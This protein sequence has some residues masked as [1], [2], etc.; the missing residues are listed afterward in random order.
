MRE[1]LLERIKNGYYKCKFDDY[2]SSEKPKLLNIDPTEEEVKKYLSELEKYNIYIDSYSNI[3]REREKKFETFKKDLFD[4][5]AYDI[6]STNKL[7]YNLLNKIYNLA[8]KD[9][10]EFIVVYYRFKEYVDVLNEIF[11]DIILNTRGINE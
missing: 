3:M 9:T 10:T 11:N 2:L 1:N 6:K 4:T 7:K 5:F 8:W